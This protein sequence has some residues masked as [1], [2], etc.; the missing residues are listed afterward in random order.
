MAWIYYHIHLSFHTPVS[1]FHNHPFSLPSE[2]KV[3]EVKGPE[4]FLSIINITKAFLNSNFSQNGFTYPPPTRNYLSLLW[5]LVCFL[6]IE[7]FLILDSK[8]LTSWVRCG[9][10]CLWSQHSRGRARRIPRVRGQRGL[11]S[12]FKASLNYMRPGL[13]TTTKNKHP[14]PDSC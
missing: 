1:F 12:T 13:K 11:H 10:S 4:S 8:T 6:V 5:N 2:V 7:T 3:P 14:L 9:G